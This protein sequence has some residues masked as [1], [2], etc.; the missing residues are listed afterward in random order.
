MP[1]EQTEDGVAHF[2]QWVTDVASG[3]RQWQVALDL[4]YSQVKQS[5]RRR[6]LARVERRMRLGDRA[7]RTERLKA[8]GVSDTLNTAFV[9]CHNLTPRHAL[10]ALSRHSW[11]AA[12]L[13]GELLPHLEWWRAYFHFCHQHLSLR[14]QLDVPQ[15][16]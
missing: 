7:H 1:T 8:L 14:L 9:E 2:G 11:A 6:R 5:Y 15:A 13:T 12:Q 16:R 10:A 4:L 3:K